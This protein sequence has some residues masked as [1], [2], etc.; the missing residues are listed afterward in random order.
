MLDKFQRN[1][2][3]ILLLEMRSSV[4]NLRSIKMYNFGDIKEISD[5]SY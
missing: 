3:I 1:E 5:F 4:E 2:R